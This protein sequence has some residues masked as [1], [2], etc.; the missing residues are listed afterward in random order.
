VNNLADSISYLSVPEL[1]SIMGDF[2][3]FG[4]LI[5]KVAYIIYDHWTSSPKPPLLPSFDVI[6]TV[7]PL[8]SFIDMDPKVIYQLKDGWSP[9]DLGKVIL[10][11]GIFGDNLHWIYLAYL[12]FAAVWCL[13]VDYFIQLHIHYFNGIRQVIPHIFDTIESIWEKIEF[14]KEIYW[15]LFDAYDR[16]MSTVLGEEDDGYTIPYPGYL[17]QDY[18]RYTVSVIRTLESI[19]EKDLE[20]DPDLYLFEPLESEIYFICIDYLLLIFDLGIISTHDEY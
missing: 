8:P 13:Y 7:I 20:Y 3:I 2:N 5:V 14:Y 15:K 19:C 18:M 9:L 4:L 16:F 17:L 1:S 10:C 12:K 11:A 6:S